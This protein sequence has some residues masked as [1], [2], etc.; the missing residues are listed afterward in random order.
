[1]PW[2]LYKN[3]SILFTCMEPRNIITVTFLAEKIQR[4]LQVVQTAFGLN[5]VSLRLD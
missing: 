3:V 1:M 4:I 2:G 5:L